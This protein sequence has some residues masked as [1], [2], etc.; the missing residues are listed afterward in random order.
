MIQGSK[1]ANIAGSFR[2]QVL[3]AHPGTQYSGKLAAQLFQYGA[4]KAFHT[5]IAIA[6]GGVGEHM[7]SVLPRS[8]RRVFANRRV[9]GLPYTHL[10]LHPLDEAVALFLQAIRRPRQS[11]LNTRNARFQGR[12][13]NAAIAG[14]TAVIGFDTSGWILAERCKTM[15]IPFVLD[16]SIGHPDNKTRIFELLRE[17]Y[18]RWSCD[19]EPRLKEVR[20]AEQ[21]EHDLARRIVV[22][23]SFTR[24]TLVENG[25]APEKIRLNPY[26][27]DCSRFISR[28]RTDHRP[29]RFCFVGS[30]TA[31]KGIPQLLEV[32]QR[33]HPADAELW[34][35]GPAEPSVARLL[36]GFHNV[37]YK[38]PVPHNEMPAVLEQCDIFV[39]PSFYEGFALVILEAMACGL[40]VITTTATAGPDIIRHGED[41]WVIAPGDDAALTGALEYCLR[42]PDET[43]ATGIRARQT[44]ERFTWDRYGERWIRILGELISPDAA[45]QVI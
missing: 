5:G 6:D 29:M 21:V 23:S 13:P 26:G 32:W 33:L 40:P 24:N 39:F 31:R 41:G 19:M 43:I 28:R 30:I 27:V 18:P 45:S 12:I 36:R 38:G 11:V 20:Q 42:H 8:L 34:L 17:R 4:L 44:A 14:A 3:L 10:R 15:G 9:L 35:I 1:I 7:L 22:A 16:Q 37:F 25:V 2:K